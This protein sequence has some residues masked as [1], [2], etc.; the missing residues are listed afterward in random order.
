MGHLNFKYRFRGPGDSD[1]LV[2]R[3][4]L[5]PGRLNDLLGE[6]PRIVCEVLVTDTD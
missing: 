6:R 4:D 3:S 5:N 2:Q 1:D